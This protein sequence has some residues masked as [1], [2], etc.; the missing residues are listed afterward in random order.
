MRDAKDSTGKDTSNAERS[1]LCVTAYIW[2]PVEYN[3]VLSDVS[4]FS[5]YVCTECLQSSHPLLQLAEYSTFFFLIE[6]VFRAKWKVLAQS[7]HP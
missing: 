5:D 2:P 3:Y 4:C 1:C 7:F 6:S